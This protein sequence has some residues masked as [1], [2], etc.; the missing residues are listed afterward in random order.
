MT[1]T[2]QTLRRIVLQA[3]FGIAL[4]TALIPI[5][6]AAPTATPDAPAQSSAAQSQDAAAP[7]HAFVGEGWG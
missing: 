1:A 6:A 2:R 4:G 5:A 3:I 7:V